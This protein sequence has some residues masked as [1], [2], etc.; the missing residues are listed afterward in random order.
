MEE[1]LDRAELLLRDVVQSC[2]ISTLVVLHHLRDLTSVL[3]KLKLYDECRLTGNCALDLAEALGRQSL[4]FRQEQA[5]TLAFIARLSVYQPRAR[6]LFTQAVSICEDVV[7]NDASHSNKEILLVVLARAGSR[8]S[9]R[10]CQWLGRAVELMTKELPPTMVSPALRGVIYYNYGIGLRELKQYSNAFEA[11]REAVS[12]R[13]I[14]VNKDPAKYNHQLAQALMNMGIALDHLGEYDDAIVAHKEALE[15][16]V[17]MSTQ[18]PLLYNKVKAKALLNYGV[19]LF[20]LNQVSEAAAVEEQ[21]ISLFRN[22]AQTGYECTT[23]LCNALHNYGS[24]CGL[25]G[26]NAQAML[27]YQE[28]IPL[29]RALAATN[30][31]EEKFLRQDLHESTKSLLAF[32]EYAKADAAAAEALKRNHGWVFRDCSFA[33]NFGACLVCREG[34]I[35]GADAPLSPA[36]AP[37]PTGETVKISVHRKR[38]KILGFFRGNRSQ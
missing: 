14:L 37:K 34:V 31:K 10:S 35:P 11:N 25:L 3:D 38:D 9:D 36:E 16:C 24:F 23:S 13:R 26:Q 19:T 27:A 15:I 32:G 33:P 12:S 1:Y 7:A 4:K 22:L 17:T 28:C 5:E 2:D 30:A 29:R 18:D 6:T 8:V 20:S 21:A